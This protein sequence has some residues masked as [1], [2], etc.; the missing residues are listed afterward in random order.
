[1]H[2]TCTA[3]CKCEFCWLCLG[4]WTDHGRRTGGF[5]ACN[6][7]ERA[8]KDGVYDEEERRREMAKSIIE[9]YTHYYERWKANDKSMKKAVADLRKMETMHMGKLCDGQ[10][11]SAL[12]VKFITE[13]WLQIIECRRVLKWTYA[14]GYYLPERENTKRQLFEYL[15]GEAES[16]LERLHECTEKDLQK[17]LTAMEPSKEFTEFRVKLSG[18]TKPTKKYFEDLGQALENDLG[19]VVLSGACCRTGNAKGSG[20]N[21]KTILRGKERGNNLQMRALARKVQG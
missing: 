2:M 18:L 6:R 7:Y 12:Q 20:R 11:E 13:A 9:K 3:P 5:Y 1:M 8:K 19:E 17:Y 21:K 14:Y 15:Q 4:S 10:G 16:W